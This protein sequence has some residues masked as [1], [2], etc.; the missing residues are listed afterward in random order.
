MIAAGCH[1]AV[2]DRAS[3]RA[4][5]GRDSIDRLSD[6]H[7]SAA[8]SCPHLMRRNT[9]DPKE[10]TM[11]PVLATLT[12]IAIAATVFG[13]SRL[14]AT[15]ASA[16]AVA[17]QQSGF[18]LLPPA[19]PAGQMTLY[20]HVK[21]LTR[22]GG[23]FE[24]QFDPAWFTT[25]VTASRGALQNTGSSDVPNDNYVV[26]EGHRLLTYLVPTSARITVLTNNGQGIAATPINVSELSRIVSGG[27]HRRLFEP[28][29]SGVWIRVHVDT[30]RSLDQQYRP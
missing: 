11:K 3:P 25:G 9:I 15:P 4:A 18:K 26:E 23:R 21:T 14:L 5:D 28:L 8:S 17:K 6:V 16:A 13:S 2:P 12:A 10:G 7:G 20:G 22:R 27:K 1:G 30:V 24:M 29:D 19:A